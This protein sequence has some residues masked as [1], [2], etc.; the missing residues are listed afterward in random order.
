MDARDPEAA[1]ES[2]RRGWRWF[3]LL[4]LVFLVGVTLRTVLLGVPPVLPLIQRDLGL[5]YTATGLLTG[6]PVLMMGGAA[7]AS[8]RVIERIGGRRAVTIGLVLLAAGALLRAPFASVVLL[9][10]FTAVLSLG[11]ALSQTAVPVLVRAWFPRH[12]GLA[13][14]LYTDGIIAGEVLAVA[15]TGPL[16]LGWLG[17]GA[18]RA[19]FVAWGLTV[20]PVILLWHVLA[21]AAEPVRPRPS[22]TV[23]EPQLA[24]S[25][26]SG[27]ARPRVR[28]WHLGLVSSGGA[29]I[30]F[31]MN[32]WIPPYN[33]ALGHGDVTALALTVLNGAQLPVSLALTLVAQRLAGERWPFITVGVVGIGAIIGLT[34]TPLSWQPIW[35][36]VLGASSVAVLVLGTALPPL[37]AGPGEVARLTGATLTIN[38][39]VAFVGPLF[40]GW[41]WDQF[42]RPVL[43]FAPVVLAGLILIVLGARLPRLEKVPEPVR[44]RP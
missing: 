29:V 27:A 30:Y 14:A 25:S 7:W 36:A 15:A 11:I 35:V 44:A 16:L 5:S 18:W 1:T 24:V 12:I 40:G 9:Y 8:G 41:L 2:N 6:L 37:L 4:G 20:I 3:A 17:E 26:R 22:R 38:Y 34:S 13:A 10:L 23:D 31:T 39:G 33:E 19:S 28:A 21:P 42:N 43:A 32:S